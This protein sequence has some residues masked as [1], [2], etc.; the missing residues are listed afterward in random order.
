MVTSVM[1]LQSSEILPADLPLK[2]ASQLKI[3]NSFE[4][5]LCA[6]FE[7]FGIKACTE[8]ESRNAAFIRDSPLYA[9]IG[10]HAVLVE[11]TPGK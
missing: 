3:P 5:K 8:I 4:K 2:I 11:I 6:A 9:I 10:K 7:T 1:V